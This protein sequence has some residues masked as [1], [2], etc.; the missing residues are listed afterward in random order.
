MWARELSLKLL[1]CIS[2]DPA[3]ESTPDLDTGL[4][5][6]RYQGA[7]RRLM[8][9]DYDGTLTPIVKTPSAATPSRLLLD[10]LTAL[11]KDEHNIVYI[12]SGRDSA[13]LQEQLGHI[14]DLG[15]SAE[16]GCFLREPKAKAWED[17]TKHMDMSW[18][19]DVEDVFRCA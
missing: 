9:F 10:S 7:A 19:Q 12:I 16:H 15:F 13:F 8:L 18:R 2:F 5:T 3:S 11:T 14:A 1:Q 17:L 4:V 6:Q